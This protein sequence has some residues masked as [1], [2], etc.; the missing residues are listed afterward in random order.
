MSSHTRKPDFQPHPATL[1][2]AEFL[3]LCEPGCQVTWQQLGEAMGCDAAC[4]HGPGRGYVTT[5][6]RIVRRDHGKVFWGRP[7]GGG[8]RCLTPAEVVRLGSHRRQKVVNQTTYARKEYGTIDDQ[9]G[10]LPADVRAEFTANSVL[11]ESLR[12][13]ASG[14]R[15]AAAL[16]RQASESQN[17]VP[18]LGAFANS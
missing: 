1:A 12:L 9:L 7:G 3:R 14:R 4:P 6:R 11:M 17:I 8:L 10:N 18:D 13:K 16:R 2:V 5:A 15:F